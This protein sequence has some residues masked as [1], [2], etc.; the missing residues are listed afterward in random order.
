MKLNKLIKRLEA[1]RAV[2]GNIDVVLAEESPVTPYKTQE[3]VRTDK[4]MVIRRSDVFGVLK[5][6]R[7]PERRR[8]AALIVRI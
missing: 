1:I 8:V 6:A 2:E 3:I 7:H 4:F 5:W